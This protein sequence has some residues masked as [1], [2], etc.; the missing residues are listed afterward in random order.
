[1]LICICDWQ[2]TTLSPKKAQKLLA[3]KAVRVIFKVL[4]TKFLYLSYLLCQRAEYPKARE[5]KQNIDE[6]IITVAT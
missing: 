1:M 5:R 4:L 2:F 3:T 6:I